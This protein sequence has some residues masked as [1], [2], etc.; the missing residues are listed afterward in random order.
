MYLTTYS[1]TVL[2][3]QFITFCIKCNTFYKESKIFINRLSLAICLTLFYKE[4]KIENKTIVIKN[5]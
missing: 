4:E 3:P 2:C 1:K 5:N